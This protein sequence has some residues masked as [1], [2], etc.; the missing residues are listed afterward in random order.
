MHLTGAK[1]VPARVSRR[2]ASHILF[3]YGTGSQ[4]GGRVHIAG[5]A[6]AVIIRNT[7]FID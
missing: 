3:G 6:Q 1:R 4:T 2:N 5:E 7:I